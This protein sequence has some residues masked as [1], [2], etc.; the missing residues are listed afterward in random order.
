MELYRCD[1]CKHLFTPGYAGCSKVTFLIKQFQIPPISNKKEYDLCKTC[2]DFMLT[3]FDE[4]DSTFAELLYGGD[5][6]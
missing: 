1:R 4:G 3:L 5:S 2:T 6:V